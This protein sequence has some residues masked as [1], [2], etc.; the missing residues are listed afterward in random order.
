MNGIN[1][2]IYRSFKLNIFR[3]EQKHG[4]NF[5]FDLCDSYNSYRFWTLFYLEKTNSDT[6]KEIAPLSN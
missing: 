6:K 5:M 2:L 1:I 3:F 4:H